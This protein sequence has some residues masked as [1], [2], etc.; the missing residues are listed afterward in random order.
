MEFGV[1]SV[2]SLSG[3]GLGR[4][5]IGLS[6]CAYNLKE[7]QRLSTKSGSN[8]LK[9]SWVDVASFCS[10]FSIL[11]GYANSPLGFLLL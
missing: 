10:W 6:I 4:G 2:Q 3:T 9:L 7:G 5:V 11:I 1:V 8:T